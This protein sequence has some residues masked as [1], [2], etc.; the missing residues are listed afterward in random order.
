M[1]DQFRIMGY[2]RAGETPAFG[3]LKTSNE[4]GEVEQ[5][6]TIDE[7][8]LGP[9]DSTQQLERQALEMA[10]HFRKENPTWK[11]WAELVQF[12]TDVDKLKKEDDS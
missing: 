4:D 3:E 5:L 2:R 8:W 1:A 10:S 6:Y 12:N 9:N 7:T 11:I